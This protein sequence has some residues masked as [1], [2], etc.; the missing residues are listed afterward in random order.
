MA[1]P[2]PLFSKGDNNTDD[3][4]ADAEHERERKED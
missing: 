1:L 3:D 2:E 4:P